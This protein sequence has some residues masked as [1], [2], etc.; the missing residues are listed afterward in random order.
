MLG[1]D[2]AASTADTEHRAQGARPFPAS[3][4]SPSALQSS[5][6]DEL[7]SSVSWSLSS[8]LALISIPSVKLTPPVCPP[9]VRET[10]KGGFLA[11]PLRIGRHIRR[12]GGFQKV[13]EDHRS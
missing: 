1:T 4:E 5:A 13:L 3:P 6:Q 9:A 11:S 2:P 7:A 12:D 10:R 8:A